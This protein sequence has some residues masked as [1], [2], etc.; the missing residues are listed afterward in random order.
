MLCMLIRNALRSQ[1][2][3]NCIANKSCPFLGCLCVYQLQF[4]ADDRCSEI[5][6]MCDEH[7]YLAF[8]DKVLH[9]NKFCINCKNEVCYPL[10]CYF[11]LDIESSFS[12]TAQ[13]YW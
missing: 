10:C 11:H 12:N 8:A 1:Y 7:F 4:L 3:S 6:L 9:A 2:S 5:W 13:I